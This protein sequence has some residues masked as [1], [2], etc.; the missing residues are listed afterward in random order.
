MKT[1]ELS[2]LTDAQLRKYNRN[3]K[4]VTALFSIVLLALFIV[5]FILRADR[6]FNSLM[7]VPISLVP[8]LYIN[9]KTLRDIK[10]EIEDRAAK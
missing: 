8:I 1:N 3:T 5:G 9:I 4:L 2:T 6:Q 7:V 10:K